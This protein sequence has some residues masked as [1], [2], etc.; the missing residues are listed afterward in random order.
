[1]R[2]GTGA[3]RLTCREGD[4]NQLVGVVLGEDASG[5]Q[6]ERVKKGV[7]AAARTSSRGRNWAVAIEATKRLGVEGVGDLDLGL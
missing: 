5:R 1:M 4:A 3:L 6:L 2:G 7:I